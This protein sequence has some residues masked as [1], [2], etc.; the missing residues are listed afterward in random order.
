MGL[1]FVCPHNA[2]VV[3]DRISLYDM[4]LIPIKEI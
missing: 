2:N 4:L 1:H 3:S